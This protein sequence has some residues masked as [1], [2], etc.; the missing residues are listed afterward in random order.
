MIFL[1]LNI[2]PA[3]QIDK[4]SHY[5]SL[6]YFHLLG[7]HHEL[8]KWPAPRLLDSSLMSTLQ[9]LDL[10]HDI[11]RLQ[12]VW[13]TYPWT[14]LEISKMISPFLQVS[15]DTNCPLKSEV[16]RSLG[17]VKSCRKIIKISLANISG[18]YKT[19]YLIIGN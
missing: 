1:R 16:T 11:N 12:S 3:V 17:S 2:F 6:S 9:S 5:Y 19:A 18:Y 14:V 8:T 10:D 15:W 7:L 13:V 4:I